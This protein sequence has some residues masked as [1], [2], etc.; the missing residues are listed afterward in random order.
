M[1]SKYKSDKQLNIP[2][3]YHH[4]SV[5]GFEHVYRRSPVECAYDDQ[6]S[7]L[8]VPSDTGSFTGDALHKTAI[9]G[10]YFD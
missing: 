10:K 7:Q 8:K 4:I 9:S 2:N 6:V 5:E 1:P 3:G